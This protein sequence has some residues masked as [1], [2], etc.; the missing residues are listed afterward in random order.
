[1]SEQKILYSCV[2]DQTGIVASVK[3]TD[4]SEQTA[5]Q[6]MG[7]IDLYGDQ[8]QAVPPSEATNG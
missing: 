8:V 7:Q 3:T 2:A 1:M 5:W 4:Q 6:I